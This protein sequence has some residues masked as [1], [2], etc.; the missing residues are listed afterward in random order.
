M[1]EIIIIRLSGTLW[2]TQQEHSTSIKEYISKPILK[3]KN[4]LI[5]EYSIHVNVHSYK[6]NNGAN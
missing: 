2:I 3:K 6:K 4:F 5:I 1:K